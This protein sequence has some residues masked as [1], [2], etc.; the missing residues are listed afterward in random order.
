LTGFPN[1]PDGLLYPG[2]RPAGW[3]NHSREIYENV[4]VFRVPVYLAP[5]Q[6]KWR[7]TLNHMSFAASACYQMRKLNFEPQIVI[8]TSPPL[9]AGEAALRIAKRHH[10][11]LVFEVRDLWPE[12]VTAVGVASP[13]NLTYRLLDRMAARLYANAWKVVPVTDRSA[14]ALVARGVEL[15]KIE[16]VKNAAD[17]DRFAPGV[18]PRAGLPDWPR[19]TGKFVVTYMG[20]LGMAHNLE[21]VLD[22]AALLKDR[23]DIHFLLVGS[24]ARRE[25][26]LRRTREKRLGNV[27]FTGARPWA[28]APQILANSDVVLIH[29]A[30]RKLF[31]TVIPSK[32]FEAMA[33]GRPIVLGVRG[34]SQRL[35]EQAGAGIAVE[36][37]SASQMREA[38]LRLYNDPGTRRAMG[39]AARSW[40]VENA[41]YDQRARQYLKAIEL[42]EPAAG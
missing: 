34:E 14:E 29:L 7:R 16:V 32:L 38:L 3:L 20:T 12:S 19:L 15:S 24:G 36:P 25:E 40:V 33:A 21:T 10:A 22:A 9:F 30:K 42:P 8:G 26:L 4:P 2:Y 11:R 28:E 39:H 17:I 13:E 41:S 37:E 35:L 5:N 18:A 6:G 27:T 1:Y 31:E 23:P